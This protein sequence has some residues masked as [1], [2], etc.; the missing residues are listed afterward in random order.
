MPGAKF[1]I[2]YLGCT[3]RNGLKEGLVKELQGKTNTA[4]YP[5][6]P[7][8]RAWN[9]VQAREKNREQ[10]TPCKLPIPPQDRA[11]NGFRVANT[12]VSLLFDIE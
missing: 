3:K 10:S 6:L 7:Q 4:I 2:T 1:G 11:W 8:D 5:S 9:G 12:R